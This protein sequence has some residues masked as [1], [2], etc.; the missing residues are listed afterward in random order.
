V[1]ID[2]GLPLSQIGR[3]LL[4]PSVEQPAAPPIAGSRKARVMVVEDE[5]IVAMNLENRIRELG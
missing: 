4:K 1:A 5:R 2:Y 3:K